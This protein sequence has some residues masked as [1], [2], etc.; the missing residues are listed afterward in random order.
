MRPHLSARHVRRAPTRAAVALAIVLP[1]LVVLA[2]CTPSQEFE[3]RVHR[4]SLSSFSAW[5]LREQAARQRVPISVV[6]RWLDHD[7]APL[8]APAARRGTLDVSTDLCSASPDRGTGFDFRWPCIRHDVAW[9][10]LRRG[11]LP[12]TRAERRRANAR[13]EADARESCVAQP[14]WWRPRCLALA[15]A[16]RTALDAV[17]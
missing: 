13:F 17:A 14:L 7:P 2:S 9:R 10:N 8:D 1:V 5:W 4:S 6:R 16:Y 12:N 11:V 3:L 15:R